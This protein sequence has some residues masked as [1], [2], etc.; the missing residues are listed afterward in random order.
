MAQATLPRLSDGISARGI[1]MAL[2][3]RQQLQDGLFAW[4][5][6]GFGI[7]VLAILGG[8]IISLID[9]AWPA[10]QRFGFG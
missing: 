1:T 7:L 3:R 8:V 10:M 5:T 9:G 6:F 2:V 4:L